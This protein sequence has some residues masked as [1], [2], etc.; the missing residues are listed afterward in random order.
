MVKSS[1]LFSDEL[2]LAEMKV[3]LY[4][5]WMVRKQQFRMSIE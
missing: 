4:G 2:S 1:D 5:G 3:Y